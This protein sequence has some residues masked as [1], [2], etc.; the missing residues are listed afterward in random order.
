MPACVEVQL[1][2][3]KILVDHIVDTS[4]FSIKTSIV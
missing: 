3:P 2:E 4:V 1:T